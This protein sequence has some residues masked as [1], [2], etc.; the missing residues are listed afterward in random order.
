MRI[1]VLSDSHDHLPALDAALA[2]LMSHGV[3]AVIHAGDFIAPF[4]AKRLAPTVLGVPVYA[5]YGNNDGERRGLRR[6][7]PVVAEGPLR[8]EL[9]GKTV[10]VDHFRDWLTDDDVAGADV[11]ITG[12]THEA[13]ERRADDRLWLNPGEVCGYVT[14]RKSC[15]VLTLNR[16]SAEVCWIS[17]D[18]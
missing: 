10:V 7:L 14:G 5:C 11:V 9:G 8:L 18:A 17:L 3:E 15:A 6:V 13:E 4:A 16:P 2:A 1:G 12:H